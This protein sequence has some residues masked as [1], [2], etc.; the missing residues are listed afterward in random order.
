M[1]NRLID[2]LPRLSELVSH[3]Y[4]VHAGSPRQLAEG[5][6]AGSEGGDDANMRYKIT[7]TTTYEYADQVPVCQNIAHLT[8]ATTTV[9]SAPTTD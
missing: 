3:K 2:Q 6:L 9:N 7:H 8:P 1:L 5:R 4:F